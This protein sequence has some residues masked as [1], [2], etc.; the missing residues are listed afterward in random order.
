MPEP[1]VSTSLVHPPVIGT[2]NVNITETSKDSIIK[3]IFQVDP[4]IV[5]WAV[6]TFYDSHLEINQD[7][8]EP[9]MVINATIYQCPACHTQKL[10][11]KEM[12]PRMY[13]FC[14]G[15]KD[16]PHQSTRTTPIDFNPITTEIGLQYI[17]GTIAGSINTNFSSANFSASD[18]DV[19]SKMSLDNRLRMY[20][21]SVSTIC[22]ATLLG[23]QSVYIQP[24]I[25]DNWQTVKVFN[26]AFLANVIS[27][28]GMNIYANATKGKN[29]SAV[30]AMATNRLAVESSSSSNIG[31]R[32]PDNIAVAEKKSISD[33]LLNGLGLGKKW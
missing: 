20:G 7:N 6:K 19:A 31:Y 17:L 24:S 16:N 18:A 4:S 12:L 32:Y 27:T 3:V 10:K 2:P 13:Q 1:S 26:A 14:N 15:Q 30:N 22:M 28:L 8:G 11:E 33:Q 25:L 5:E 23:N 29:A 9:M 21:W